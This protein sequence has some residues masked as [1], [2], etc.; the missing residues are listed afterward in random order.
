MREEESLPE[1]ALVTKGYT[2]FA[3]RIGLGLGLGLD[4]L[5]DDDRP[6]V[7]GKVVQARRH[8]LASWI[9]IDVSH[10]GSVELHEILPQFQNVAQTRISRA[11]IVNR[12]T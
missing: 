3:Q 2:E 10:D 1:D 5:G 4:A 12:R 6:V 9:R 11:G 8:C 7:I